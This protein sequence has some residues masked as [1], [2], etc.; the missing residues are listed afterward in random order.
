MA[1]KLAVIEIPDDPLR[2]A[3]LKI[4]SLSDIGH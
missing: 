4:S 3:Q 2:F 1:T